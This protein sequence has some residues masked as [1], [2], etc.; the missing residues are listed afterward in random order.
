MGF[1]IEDL[2]I[3]ANNVVVRNLNIN[4]VDEDGAELNS[5]DGELTLGGVAR[6][7]KLA[8]VQVATL[9]AN[10]TSTVTLNE[11]VV[12]S[13]VDSALI[14]NL[15]G[16][17][18]MLNG[19]SVSLGGEINDLVLVLADPEGDDEP[20]G[21][22]TLDGATLEDLVVLAT[23]G[24]ENFVD[25]LY[26]EGT[27]TLGTSNS[28]LVVSGL[29]EL[30]GATV[31][32]ASAFVLDGAQVFEGDFARPVTVEAE[33]EGNQIHNSTLAAVLT[34]DAD[35]IMAAPVF[36]ST[37]TGINVAEDATLTLLG[38]TF[39]VDNDITALE[40]AVVDM[41]AAIEIAEDATLTLNGATAEFTGLAN[42][43][44]PD[45]SRTC[46]RWRWFLM[47]NCNRSRCNL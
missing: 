21:T 5:G 27:L 46:W 18:H 32:G 7:I 29:V 24:G 17:V 31:T 20:S 19:G 2:E 38:G 30:N 6:N 28:D 36:S 3:N 15:V 42:F 39:L 34:V 13:A 47:A 23:M 45:A 16:P 22:L 40:D 33:S 11:V 41:I 26:L 25:G 43:C 14:L 37:G 9:D 4:A 8:N 10:L 1:E 35:L 12:T 44:S